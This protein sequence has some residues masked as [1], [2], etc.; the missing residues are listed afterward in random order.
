MSVKTED[1]DNRNTSTKHVCYKNDT[2]ISPM[3]EI[4]LVLTNHSMSLFNAFMVM[5]ELI[6]SLYQRT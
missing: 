5:D 1:Q 4:D 3:S 6:D 2:H